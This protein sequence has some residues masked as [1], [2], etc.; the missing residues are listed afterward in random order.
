[1]NRKSKKNFH[2]SEKKGIVKAVPQPN[3]VAGAVPGECFAKGYNV[4][5]AFYA[6]V[7]MNVPVKQER[8]RTDGIG[9]AKCHSGDVFDEAKGKAVAS[10]KSDIKIEQDMTVE[11]KKTAEMLR[12]AAEEAERL[13][14]KHAKKRDAMEASLEKYAKM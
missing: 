6:L 9:V 8:T 10:M 11:Y 7:V 1:M 2:V 14:L 5:A 3:A 13:A 4:L 12:K